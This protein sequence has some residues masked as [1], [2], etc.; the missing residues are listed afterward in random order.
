MQDD[1]IVSVKHC[2]RNPPALQDEAIICDQIR[3]SQAG[4]PVVTIQMI[5]AS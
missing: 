1:A 4:S 2:E 5:N 3:S